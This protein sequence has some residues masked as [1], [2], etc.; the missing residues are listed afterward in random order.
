MGRL[1]D[2][3]WH[4]AGESLGLSSVLFRAL[5]G[6]VLKMVKR[7]DLQTAQNFT[8]LKRGRPAEM[9]DRKYKI[10]FAEC[11]IRKQLFDDS[12]NRSWQSCGAV[13]YACLDVVESYHQLI[14]HCGFPVR[15]NTMSANFVCSALLV[16]SPH[17][18]SSP[19]RWVQPLRELCVIVA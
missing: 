10:L 19:I 15:V 18:H 7:R 4:R 13:T 17:P 3:D 6:K 16:T 14:E 12:E 1:N 8:F 9:K 5:Q 2:P 11:L